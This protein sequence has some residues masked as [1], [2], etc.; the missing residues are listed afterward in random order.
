VD[1]TFLRP[2]KDDD[3]VAQGD[4]LHLKAQTALEPGTNE[5][6]QEKD[7]GAHGKRRV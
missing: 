6:N 5:G 1:T 2:S 7:W 4:D 3:L